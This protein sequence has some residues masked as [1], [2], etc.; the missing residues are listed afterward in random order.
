M[1]ITPTTSAPLVGEPTDHEPGV[2]PAG[3]EFTGPPSIPSPSSDQATR[4]RPEELH[5]D[6]TSY[7]VSPT[8]GVFS[9]ATLA[10]GARTRAGVAV[11]D[12][13][14]RVRDVYDRVECGRAA[15]SEGSG[16]PWCRALG[17]VHIFFGENPIDS[18]TLSVTDVRG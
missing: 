14:A 16:Y 5:Y 2:F 7:L 18:I 3:R 6:D 13:L 4:A 12:K 11:G 8:A 17:D 9:M 1:A 15:R 10:E